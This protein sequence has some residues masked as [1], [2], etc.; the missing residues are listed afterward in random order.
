MKNRNIKP[1]IFEQFY[2]LVIGELEFI[3]KHNF[4]NYSL[5]IGELEFIFKHNFQ[6]LAQTVNYYLVS[7]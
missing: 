6:K 7:S 5:V 2:G 1:I 4:Q 3:F